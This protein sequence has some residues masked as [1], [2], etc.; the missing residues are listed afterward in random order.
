MDSRFQSSSTPDKK[1]AYCIGI[2]VGTSG[3]RTLLIDG[4]GECL[5]R[6]MLTYEEIRAQGITIWDSEKRADATKIFST[7]LARL[8]VIQ[9]DFPDCRIRAIGISC[10]HPSLVCL[11]PDGKPLGLA[12][13]YAY[14]GAATYL[15]QLPP[16]FQAST[17][18]MISMAI[19]YVQLR[20]I[21]QES[22]DLH[23]AKIVPLADY[24]VWSMT[25][26]GLEKSFVGRPTASYSGLYSVDTHTWH[27]GR[28]Q[29]VGLK[30]S[31]MPAI[32]ELGTMY[33]VSADLQ[34]HFPILQGARVAIGG[35]DGLDAFWA[36]GVNQGDKVIVGSASTSGALRRWNTGSIKDLKSPLIYCNHVQGDDWVVVLP[37][38]NVGTSLHWLAGKFKLWSWSEYLTPEGLLDLDRLDLEAEQRLD[39]LSESAGEY[40]SKL[41]LYFPYIEGEP[42]GPGGRGSQVKGGLI[43]RQTGHDAIDLYIALI[44]GIVN[45]YKHVLNNLDTPQDYQEIRLTG[46]V[47]RKC[48]L[49]CHFLATASNCQVKIMVNEQS[50][51]W[52]AGLRA[53][54]SVGQIDSL[55]QVGT[56]EP[57]KPLGG[58]E[59]QALDEL[60]GRY[61][62][63]YEYWER[64]E[65]EG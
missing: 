4:Q 9:A 62:D 3:I 32:R 5:D 37:F 12:T 24:L 8:E 47:A 64:I 10:F 61:L 29:E 13:T 41:P 23:P 56:L 40:L 39:D 52:V 18:A 57:F 51:A 45:M 14:Q 28:L 27:E 17:G 11:D 54:Q 2:D 38:N 53:L 21:Q 36:V 35:Y 65:I 55:P 46:L 48:P 26:L 60:F 63:V 16:D 6:D 7:I 42:R 1:E 30:T 31:Q 50:V 15:N 33:A 43:G 44:L 59:K 20:Q 25:D 34:A 58:L 49:F 19:P 22:P